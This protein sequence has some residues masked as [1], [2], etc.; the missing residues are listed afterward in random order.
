MRSTRASAG[1]I[2]L[3]V[4]HDSNVNAATASN[5]FAIPAFGGAVFTL[6]PAAQ[7]QSDGYWGLNAGFSGRWGV[8]ESIGVVASGSVENKSNF[9]L[10]QFNTG[11]L[12]ASAG[13]SI[14][15]GTTSEWLIAAQGQKYFVENNTFRNGV[16][17]VLQYRNNWTTNDQFSIYGQYTKLTYPDIQVRDANRY[18]V[19]VAWAHAY[20]LRSGSPVVYAGAYAV[21]EDPEAANVPHFGHNLYG[22]RAGGQMGLADRWL[23][24]VS[25]NYEERR[26]GGPDPLFLGDRHDREF[27]ARAA[28]VYQIDK[29]WS[30]TP[31]VSYTKVTSNFVVNEYDRWM[32]SV[33]GSYDFR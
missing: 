22:V 2:E 33:F 6:A 28:A 18:V 17:G 11:S 27:Y 26:Y 9:D 30:V 3:G 14:R 5:N 23:G 8:T 7:K 4:G 13:L 15:R 16:G 1:Y 29:N 31:G 19:G 20:P 25:A 24:T 21:K 32:V 10:D 12:N